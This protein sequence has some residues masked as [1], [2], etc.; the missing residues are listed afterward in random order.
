MP[1][2]IPYLTLPYPTIDGGSQRAGRYP[3][4]QWSYDHMPDLDA[5]PTWGLV[6]AWVAYFDPIKKLVDRLQ[7]NPL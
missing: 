2:Y 4:R 5:L 3:H 6:A 7:K 1:T